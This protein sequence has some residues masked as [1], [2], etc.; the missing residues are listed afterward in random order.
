[1]EHRGLSTFFDMIWNQ[2]D[3]PPKI[4]WEYIIGAQYDSPTTSNVDTGAA[5]NSS[6][7]NRTTQVEVDGDGWGARLR[8]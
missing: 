7:A 8:N 2:A 6:Y 4:N 5:S 3:E 1:M